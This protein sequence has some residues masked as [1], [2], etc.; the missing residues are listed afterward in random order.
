MIKKISLVFAL[1]LC[2]FAFAKANE[3]YNVCLDS[4]DNAEQTL[5]L[6]YGLLKFVYLS[7]GQQGTVYVSMENTTPSQAILAFKYP[8]SEKQLKSY[9]PKVEFEKTYPGS[10]GK[11]SVDGCEYLDMV[12]I[13]VTP[14]ANEQ[15]LSFDVDASQNSVSLK[16]PLYLAKFDVKKWMKKGAFGVNYKILSED[17]LDLNVEVSIWTPEDPEYKAYASQIENLFIDLEGASF[18]NSSK[19]NPSFARQIKPY[20]ERRD[21]LTAEIEKTLADHPEWKTGSEPAEAFGNLISVLSNIDFNNY[22]AD[23][24]RHG[25]PP[26]KCAYCNLSAQQIYHQ[27]DDVYQQQ[28][29]GKL[30]KAEATKK[31]KAIYSCYTSNNKRKKDKEYADKISKFYSRIIQ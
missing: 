13:P 6:P 9:K 15:I 30:S 2:C 14:Q 3:E 7:E 8:L 10:K 24:G 11:R 21:K 17:I 27:L 18:C 26:H 23:C 22:A 12:W 5:E 25:V 31:A 1:W 16:L 20:E 28:R 29:T 4:G 19:H